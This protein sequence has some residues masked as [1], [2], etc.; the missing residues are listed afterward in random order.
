MVGAADK[1]SHVSRPSE[2]LPH[3]Q[4]EE[5]QSKLS[6]SYKIESGAITPNY[7]ASADEKSQEK[8]DLAFPSSAS[9]ETI[10]NKN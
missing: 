5:H 4:Q 9:A 10:Q 2:W 8:S 7:V 6:K 1:R 3:G